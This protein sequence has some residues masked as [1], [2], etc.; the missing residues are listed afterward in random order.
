MSTITHE[1]A[2]SHIQRLYHYVG[3]IANNHN[4]IVGH[5]EEIR[6]NV[7]NLTENVKAIKR[8]I[9]EEPVKNTRQH[10]RSDPNRTYQHPYHQ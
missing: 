1:N 9:Q 3:V 4:K 5:L 8:T 6:K 7:N 10:S 2:P